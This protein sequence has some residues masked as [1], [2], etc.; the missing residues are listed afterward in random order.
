MVLTILVLAVLVL[1]D[2]EVLVGI[3]IDVMCRFPKKKITEITPAKKVITEI[4]V[5]TK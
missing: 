3:R 2:M 4:A 5:I 1:I